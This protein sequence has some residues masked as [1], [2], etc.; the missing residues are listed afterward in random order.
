VSDTTKW[1]F[2]LLIVCF[3]IGT[4]RMRYRQALE[5]GHTRSAIVLRTYAD[6]W[7]RLRVRLFWCLFPAAAV[8][9]WLWLVPHQPVIS[10]ATVLVAA[11]VTFGGAIFDLCLLRA[12]A[13]NPPARSNDN[14]GR[15]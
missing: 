1:L 7:A 3:I 11:S 15:S 4:V 13:K 14:A 8:A 12:W 10:L 6:L 5:T 2:G 9:A